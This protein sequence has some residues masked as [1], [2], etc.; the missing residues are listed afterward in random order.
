[1]CAKARRAYIYFTVDEVKDKFHCASDKAMKLIRELDSDK[2]IGL[3]QYCYIT[4][5]LKN[6]IDT[7]SKRI[8]NTITDTMSEYF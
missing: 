7:V 6:Y 8:Y 2:G 5:F 1:M 4:I 3:I